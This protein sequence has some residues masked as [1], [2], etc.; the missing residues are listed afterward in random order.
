MR[1]NAS[2]EP[3]WRFS[4]PEPTPIIK[5]LNINL[6]AIRFVTVRVQIGLKIIRPVSSVR[7]PI[8]V[9]PRENQCAT[10]RTEIWQQSARGGHRPT[11]FGD[12]SKRVNVS[13]AG[14]KTR[15]D[16]SLCSGVA[17]VAAYLRGKP[18]DGGHEAR[19]LQP[20]WPA[21]VSSVWLAVRLPKGFARKCLHP[22]P[23]SESRLLDQ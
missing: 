4:L 21:A 17:H 5:C 6:A 1:T 7:D 16:P 15:V 14:V 8:G 12:E 10:G 3:A 22:R 13:D 9:K 23:P 20:R 19:R 18:S 2:G 11:V